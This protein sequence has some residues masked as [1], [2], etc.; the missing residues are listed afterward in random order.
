MLRSIDMMRW[1]GGLRVADWRV[2]TPDLAVAAFAAIAL[3]LAV[4][5][6]PRRRVLACAGLA[7]LATASLLLA[8]HA[9]VLT[10]CTLS[11]KGL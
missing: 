11:T 10:G 2:P 5:L 6:A 1:V 7:M 3:F 4:S 8:F 9:R